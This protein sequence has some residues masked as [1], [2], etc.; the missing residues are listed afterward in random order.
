MSTSIIT[1][2]TFTFAT[3]ID[4]VPFSAASTSQMIGSELEASEIAACTFT[5]MPRC[6]WAARKNCSRRQPCKS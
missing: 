6:A 1:T 3:V 4:F 5:A 2:T